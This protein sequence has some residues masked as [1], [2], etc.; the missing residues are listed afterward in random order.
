MVLDRNA[1]SFGAGSQDAGRLPIVLLI[2]ETRG[3]VSRVAWSLPTEL[4]SRHLVIGPRSLGLLKLAPRCAGHLRTDLRDGGAGTF[5]SAVRALLDDGEI[6]IAI[7]ADEAGVRFLRRHPVDG[8]ILAP[9][10]SQAIVADFCN[11]WVFFATCTRLGVRTPNTVTYADK[12]SIDFLAIA[13]KFRY[14]LIVKPVTGTM[15][16]GVVLAR[17]EAHLKAA[18]VDNAG[19]DFGPLLVQD[20]IAGADIQIGLFAT[21][22]IILNHVVQMRRRDGIAFLRNDALLEAARV[23]MRDCDYTGLAHMDARI[24]PDGHVHVLECNP[25]PW[26]SITAPTWCGLNFVRASIMFAMGPAF[27]TGRAANCPRSIADCSAPAPWHRVRAIM[28]NPLTWKRLTADQKRTL[29]SAAWLALF[30]VQDSLS[31]AAERIGFRSSHRAAALRQTRGAPRRD[32]L[33]P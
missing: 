5:R 27:T 21:D 3:L 31:R 26:G 19:W 12:T 11:K 1:P 29:G 15:S 25:R 32:I 18:V 23:L 13:D 30:A 16:R 7:P 10:P 28:R 17:S 9:H 2:G 6:V 14:P 20:F 4:C 24:D 33:R 22:G 8:L